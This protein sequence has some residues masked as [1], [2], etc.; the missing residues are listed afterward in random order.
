MLRAS[1]SALVPDTIPEKANVKY[2]GARCGD[3]N[4]RVNALAY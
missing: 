1:A 3:V 4:G 2:S